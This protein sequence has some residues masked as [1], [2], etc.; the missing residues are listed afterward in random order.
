MYNTLTPKNKG[1]SPFLTN[2]MGLLDSS[3][4]HT[5]ITKS[6][7]KPSPAALANLFRPKS[8]HDKARRN[9]GWVNGSYELWK[10]NYSAKTYLNIF[11]RSLFVIALQSNFFLLDGWTVLKVSWNSASQRMTLC[12]SDLNFSHSMISMKK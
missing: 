1:G 10:S 2:S 5:R 8:L 7:V 9:M 11:T 4:D 12:S 3:F 6:P